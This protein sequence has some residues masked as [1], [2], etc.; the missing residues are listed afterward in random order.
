MKTRAG[1]LAVLALASAGC[2]GS[3][4]ESGLEP[5]DTYQLQGAAVP[6]RGGRLPLAI[7]VGRVRAPS[8][9]ETERIAVLQP[10]SRFDYFAGVRWSEPAPQMLQQQLVRVLAADGRFEAVVAA[11]SRVPTDLVIDVE[12]RR[13]EAVYAAENA[14]PEIRV[15][16]QVAVLDA[17]TV[18]RVASFTVAAASAAQADRRAAVIAAFERATADAIGMAVAK[19]RES[20][21]ASQR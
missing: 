16:M 15:E 20:V 7:G 3:L 5:P 21:P 18:E 17:R 9:L 1:L 2:A 12:L 11:P 13:F 8:S 19:L 4:L 6:D 14:A 10:D